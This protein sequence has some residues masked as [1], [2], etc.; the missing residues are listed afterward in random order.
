MKSSIGL[1]RRNFMKK[2]TGW[3]LSSGA[4]AVAK[5]STVSWPSKPLVV[6]CRDTLVK[7][8]TLGQVQG[9]IGV[10]GVEVE[11]NPELFCP[12]LES[13]EGGEKIQPDYAVSHRNTQ[14]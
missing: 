6:A 10:T 4:L 11:V 9:L 2:T 13:A 3:M 1:T 7:G 5:D 8:L 12:N 14:R